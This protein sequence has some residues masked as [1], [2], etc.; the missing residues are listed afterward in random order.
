MIDDD[1]IA[2][3]ENN[4]VEKKVQVRPTTLHVHKHDRTHNFC[5]A[6]LLSLIPSQHFFSNRVWRVLGGGG[7]QVCQK[8][9]HKVPPHPPC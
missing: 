6:D 8:L 4:K 9:F 5:K 3:M 1:L 7:S 2:D